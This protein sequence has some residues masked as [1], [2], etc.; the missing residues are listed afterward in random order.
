M[1]ECKFCYK[2]CEDW[3]CP[4]C[5]RK[6]TINKKIKAKEHKKDYSNN[7]PAFS[8]LSVMTYW[9]RNKRF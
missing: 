4:S 3:V 2:D 6:I 8:C 9:T 5:K 7:Y 1:K